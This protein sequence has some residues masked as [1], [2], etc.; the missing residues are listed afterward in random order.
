[1]TSNGQNWCSLTCQ[2]TTT[3]AGVVTT[4][5]PRG[6]DCLVADGANQGLCYE[7]CNSTTGIGLPGST[8]CPTGTSCKAYNIATPVLGASGFACQ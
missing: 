1:M 7:E 2:V 8:G 3:V 6:F 4:N 5:C